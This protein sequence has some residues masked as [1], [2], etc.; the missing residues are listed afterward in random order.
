MVVARRSTSAARGE[1]SV[2][3]ACDGCDVRRLPGRWR[4]GPGAA[5]PVIGRG[6]RAARRATTTR[7]GCET[8]RA[9][10]T[11]ATTATETV[12]PGDTASTVGSAA[13]EPVTG[14][15]GGG[16]AAAGAAGGATGTEP[17]AGAG[18][19]STGT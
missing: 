15:A 11:P 1:G 18:A 6:E 7:C 8:P 10:S 9:D 4:T 13:G 2:T 12:G 19:A 3:G 5:A 17:E 14:A 16:S